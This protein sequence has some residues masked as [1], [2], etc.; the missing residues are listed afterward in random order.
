MLDSD[1]EMID[2]SIKFHHGEPFHPAVNQIFRENTRLRSID[3]P[4][5]ER[6]IR[7]IEPRTRNSGRGRGHAG[8]VVVDVGLVA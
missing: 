2:F 3:L 6:T 5:D 4:G 8:G 7:W 1:L